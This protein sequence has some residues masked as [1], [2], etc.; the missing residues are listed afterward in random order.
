MFAPATDAARIRAEYGPEELRAMEVYS[1]T[2]T[3]LHAA[4]LH[5]YI[6]TR[7]GLAVCAFAPDGS[8]L[9][10]ASH[11]ALP[12]QRA[13]LSGW[14]ITHVPED[15]NCPSWRCTV[16]DT[17]PEDPDRDPPGDLDLD[18]AAEAVTAHL[19]SCPRTVHRSGE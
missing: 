10:V 5:P 6:E 18:A 17:T 8:L 13:S 15:T 7:G 4:G 19:A 12:L 2:V 1:D 9:V 14:H 11:D 3:A 16:Y